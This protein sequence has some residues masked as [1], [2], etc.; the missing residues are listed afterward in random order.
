MLALYP[1][2][3]T[4]GPSGAAPDLGVLVCEREGAVPFAEGDFLRRLSL[5]AQRIGMA[6]VAFAPWTWYARGNSVRG[7][8]WNKRERRWTARICKVPRVVYDRAW[9]T[10]DTERRRFQ[11][12]LGRL[13][14]ANALVFLNGKL[15]DK[16][17]VGELLARDPAFAALMPPTAPYEGTRSL[18]DWLAA[19]GGAAFLKPAAGSQGKRA[20]ACRRVAGGGIS[21]AGRTGGNLPFARLARGEGE[22]L[23]ALHRWIGARAYIMQPLLSLHTASG[24]PYDVR[25]LLQKDDRRRWTITGTA[26]RVGSPGTVTANLHGGGRAVPVREALGPLFG[27]TKAREIE[28]D[29][30]DTSL[31]LASRLEETFGRFAELGLDFG[32]DRSGKLWFLEANSKPGR[33]AM[34]SAG[35]DIARTAVA[36]PLSYAST[37]LFRHLGG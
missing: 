26:A 30:R 14:E 4:L 28:Q 2:S 3:R 36:R 37:I 19:H 25:A 11:V 8:S 16:R 33:A 5:E 31:R 18:E 17:K 22:A 6:L 27:E 21:L 32:V 24:E 7:W 34:R 20:I 13:R 15:P 12:A 1:D 9:P 35:D 29:V 10:T 23:R